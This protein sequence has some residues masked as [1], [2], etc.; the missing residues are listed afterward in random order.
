[1]IGIVYY[2]DLVNISDGIL[3]NSR[4][5]YYANKMLVQYEK[6][7]WFRFSKAMVSGII[8]TLDIKTVTY[9]NFDINLPYIPIIR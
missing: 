6:T 4:G 3:N 8:T 9:N 2:N 1:M 7:V 5:F